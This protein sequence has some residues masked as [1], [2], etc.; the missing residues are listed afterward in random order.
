VRSAGIGNHPPLLGLVG[1][2]GGVAAGGTVGLPA[3]AT[4]LTVAGVAVGAFG[5]ADDRPGAGG[6]L[7]VELRDT[8]DLKR[9]IRD[10]RQLDREVA[11]QLTKELRGAVAPITSDVRSMYRGLPSRGRRGRKDPP[12]RQLLASATR[13]QVRT[14]R[15]DTGIR[16]RVDGR[17]MPPGMRSLPAMVEGPPEG[18]PWR[19]PVYG[20]RNVWVPQR[21]PGRFYPTVQ[22]HEDDFHRR[23]SSVVN[24]AVAWFDRGR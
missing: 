7:R 23:A 11:K 24:Q 4:A 3:L 5:A 20:N 8:G 6:G 18:K 19:H 2:A 17:R 21:S 16:V 14:A 13:G 15:K 12:L 1:S 9:L 10:L 22:R